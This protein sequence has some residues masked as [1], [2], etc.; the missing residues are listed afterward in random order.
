MSAFLGITT[1][2]NYMMAVEDFDRHD[3]SSLRL[4]KYGGGPMPESVVRADHGALPVRPDAGLRPDGGVHDEHPAALGAPRDPRRDRHPS[5]GELR[6]EVHLTSVRVVDEAGVPV[7]RDR[8]ALGE[9]VVKSPA[10]MVGYWRRPD[11]TAQTSSA[12]EAAGC[13]RATSRP[14]TRTASSTSSTAP[15]TW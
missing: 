10:N 13:G 9:I 3:L 5:R 12:T 2:L 1:M 8:S 6:A 7:A 11:L 14:G 15:R 4:I